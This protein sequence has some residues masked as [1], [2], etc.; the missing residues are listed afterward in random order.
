MYSITFVLVL[1]L[2]FVFVG[3]DCKNN[4]TAAATTAVDSVVLHVPLNGTFELDCDTLEA[5]VF[6]AG[7]KNTTAIVDGLNTTATASATTAASAVYSMH[8]FKKD[9]LVVQV[10]NPRYR[11]S[12]AGLHNEGHFECGS[13]VLDKFG[14]FNY[15]LRKA[16]TVKI[17]GKS[18]SKLACSFRLSLCF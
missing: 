10:N 5:H 3:V 7:E 13:N 11:I 16:W 4:T 6:A 17:I 9:E 15:V 12:G 1:L 8:M 18:S 14:R 2:V